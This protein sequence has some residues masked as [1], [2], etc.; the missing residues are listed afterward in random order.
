MTENSNENQAIISIQIKTSEYKVVPGNSVVIPL[1]LMNRSEQAGNYLVSVEGIPEGWVSTPSPLTHLEAQEQKQITLVIQPPVRTEGGPG[2]YPFII[3]VVNQDDPAQA[4]KVKIDLTVAAY[5]VEGRIGVMLEATQ[6]SVSPGSSTTMQLL[7]HNQGL[8]DDAFRLAI[9]GLQAGWIST[10]SPVTELKAGEQRQVTLTILPPATA[11]SKAGRHPFKLRVISE[12]VPDQA[13]EID[14]LLTVTAFSA[15][16][17]ELDPLQIRSGQTGLIRILNLG[18]FQETCTIS[19][20]SEEDQIIFDP[21]QEQQLQIPAGESAEVEYNARPAKRTFIGAEQTTPFL[22]QVSTSD[23]ESQ[24]TE[25]KLIS[26][27]MLPFWLIPLIL[28]LCMSV[29][30]IMSIVYIRARGSEGAEATQTAVAAYET[31][32]ALFTPT[33]P[34]DTQEPDETIVPTETSPDT[35][36]PTPLP[37]ETPVPSATPLPTELP[38]EVPTQPPPTNTP[39]VIPNVGVVAYQSNREGDPELYA[40]DTGNGAIARLTNSPGVDTQPAYSPDGSRIA[41]V[42]DRDGNNEIYL[43]NADGSAFANLSN[44]PAS[45]QNPSWSPDG[46]WIAFSSDRDGDLDIYRMRSDGSEVQNLTGNDSFDDQQPWWFSSGGLFGRGESIVFTSNRDGNNEIYI[47]GPDG[48][49]QARLTDNPS[50]DNTPNSRGD[51]IAFTSVRDGNPEIYLMGLDG[52]NPTNLTNSS[53]A[54]QYP[55][56]SRDN[57]W[58]AF[59]TDRDGN[60]E[61]YIIRPH[62]SEFYNVTNNPAA[63]IVPAWR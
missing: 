7:L 49:D 17:V 32:I 31:E 16:N 35:P 56:F 15:F 2:S 63:D 59:I 3:R 6:Y 36:E 23:G 46:Q 24:E 45:D 22:V 51:R 28:I 38:T 19:T 50:D 37:S 1:R 60:S 52:S 61:I 55:R 5:E 14:C 42:T 33:I 62:G 58:I 12:E 43:M 54:D 8:V 57:Q 44:N 30:C 40:Q 18:N 13:V 29:I 47:M 41:F 20:S 34:S 4:A 39:V 9:E 27:P 10:P 25:G 53:S 26:E 21:P 48:A 11:D